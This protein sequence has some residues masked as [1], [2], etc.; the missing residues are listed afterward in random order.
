MLMP[1]EGEVVSDPAATALQADL[2][3]VREA[4]LN[5]GDQPTACDLL[6]AVG[7]IREARKGAG[8]DLMRAWNSAT[9]EQQGLFLTAIGIERVA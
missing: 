8:V 3:A 1:P 6:T 5:V 7:L 2:L 9:A 4:L